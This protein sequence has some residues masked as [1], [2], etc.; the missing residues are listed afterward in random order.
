MRYDKWVERYNHTALRRYV[1]I[2]WPPGVPVNYN[3]P[4]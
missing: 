1:M 3:Y 4:Y 2:K